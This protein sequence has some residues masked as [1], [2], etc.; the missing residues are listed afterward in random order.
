MNIGQE[1]REAV[2]RMVGEGYQREQAERMAVLLYP[3]PEATPVT[4]QEPVAEAQ[5]VV[6]QAQEPVA[7]ATEVQ[8]V[9]AASNGQ[10]QA[11]NAEI[12]AWAKSK[13]ISVNPRGSVSAEVRAKYEKA[14]KPRRTR[15]KA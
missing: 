2:S 12:R 14:H 7:G 15:A 5:P 8:A 3:D 10:P 4:P 9:P 11:S 1:R 6:E 13:G